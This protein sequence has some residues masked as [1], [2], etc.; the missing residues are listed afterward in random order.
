[1]YLAA[2]RRV[3]AFLVVGEKGLSVSPVPMVEV[4]EG[5]GD[6]VVVAVVVE[7][8]EDLENRELDLKLEEEKTEEDDDEVQAACSDSAFGSS[9]ARG[10]PDSL[11]SSVWLA[12]ASRMTN[13]YTSATLKPKSAMRQ[14]GSS[15]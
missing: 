6:G 14:H 10:Q 4:R 1:M 2:A 8:L 7:D 15:V 5:S 11:S 12:G 13:M 3:F 9:W